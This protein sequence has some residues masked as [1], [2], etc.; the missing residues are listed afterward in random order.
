MKLEIGKKVCY[1]PPYM[2]PE[3]YEN[4]IV[5]TLHQNSNKAFVVYN[6]GGEW[7]NYRNYT[8]ALTDVSDLKEGWDERARNYVELGEDE[9]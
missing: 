6:C 9:V 5:K 2:E 3:Q 1:C 7:E 8:A 4:G